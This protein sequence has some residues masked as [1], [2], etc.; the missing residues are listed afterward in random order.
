MK[1][2]TFYTLL[3][4]HL[5]I[6]LTCGQHANSLTFGTRFNEKMW[7]QIYKNRICKFIRHAG[8]FKTEP[9]T[10]ISQVDDTSISTESINNV[11]TPTASTVPVR[12]LI[13]SEPQGKNYKWF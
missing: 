8:C 10:N 5:L 3:L 9:G 12:R 7:R 6:Y 4:F 11:I 1:Y 2:V 13:L